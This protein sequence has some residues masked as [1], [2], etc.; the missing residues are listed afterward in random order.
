M[1]AAT[2]TLRTPSRGNIGV[3]GIAAF[4]DELFTAFC[5]TAFKRGYALSP[6]DRFAVCL[7]SSQLNFAVHGEALQTTFHEDHPLLKLGTVMLVCPVL[8]LMLLPE[9]ALKPIT[10][11]THAIFMG[12]HL[13]PLVR[14]MPFGLLLN[15]RNVPFG[16]LLEQCSAICHHGILLSSLLSQ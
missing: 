15:E 2:P 10:T 13:S 5:P 9:G 1:G 6:S 11:D 16:S 3:S 7:Q 4:G 8:R 12:G 14:N